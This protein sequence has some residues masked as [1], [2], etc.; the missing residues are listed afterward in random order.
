ML[1]WESVD[2]VRTRAVKDWVGRGTMGICRCWSYFWVVMSQIMLVDGVMEEVICW[3]FKIIHFVYVVLEQTLKFSGTFSH[4]LLLNPTNQYFPMN[5]MLLEVYH[6]SPWTATSMCLQMLYWYAIS[7]AN[8]HVAISPPAPGL[9]LAHSH[10]RNIS[11][12]PRMG[13]VR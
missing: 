10:T 13:C 4:I 12:L 3:M 1:W 8:V 7:S 2:D 6:P 5:I 9:V 11:W